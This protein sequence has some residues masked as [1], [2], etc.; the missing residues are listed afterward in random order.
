MAKLILTPEVR[1]QFLDALREIPNVV[2]AARKVGVSRRY[3]Y[4]VYEA[5]PDFAK[6]WDDAIAEGVESIEAE[7]HRRA[8]EGYPGRPVVSNGAIL[9]EVVEYSDTLAIFLAKAHAP[10]KYREASK[11]ELT[12]RDGGPVQIDDSTAAA[13]LA[14]LMNLAQTRKEN[15]PLA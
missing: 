9:S 11:L 12:G 14:A 3:M 4:D 7:M 8:Y 1:E 15:E 10:E 5:E 2:R 13:K 6:R